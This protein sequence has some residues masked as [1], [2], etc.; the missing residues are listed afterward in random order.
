MLC[1]RLLLNPLDN[2]T[3]GTV[4]YYVTGPGCYWASSEAFI[5][6]NQDPVPPTEMI[7]LMFCQ[8]FS[9]AWNLSARHPCGHC[10]HH[11][12]V[13]LGTV[14]MVIWVYQERKTRVLVSVNSVCVCVED[15]EWIYSFFIFSLCTCVLNIVLFSV[16][17]FEVIKQKQSKCWKKMLG[18]F[19]DLYYVVRPM[20]VVSVL[21]TG[22]LLYSYP[23]FLKNTM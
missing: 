20:M 21:N 12:A 4:F 1:R 22:S 7:L 11:R 8:K 16:V 9:L 2:H 23:Y 10:G 5:I 18:C 19:F 14:D 17:L 15:R 6:Y 3:K 13:V